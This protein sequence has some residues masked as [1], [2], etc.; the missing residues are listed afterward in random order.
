MKLIPSYVNH[1]QIPP[2]VSYLISSN[3]YKT[4]LSDQKVYKA[5][6]VPKKATW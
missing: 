5:I 4:V 6:M 1:E 3:N 2:T